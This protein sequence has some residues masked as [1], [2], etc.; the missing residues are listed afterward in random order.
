MKHK[1]EITKL[2]SDYERKLSELNKLID[3]TNASSNKQLELLKSD[4]MSSTKALSEQ[5]EKSTETI[6]SLNKE[7][8]TLKLKLLDNE[9]QKQ[10]YKDIAELK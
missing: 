10:Q 5:N 9:N 7:I 6:K 2:K 1:A 3:S 8:E 4:F